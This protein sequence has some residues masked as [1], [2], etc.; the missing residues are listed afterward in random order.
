M[1]SVHG[2]RATRDGGTAQRF[3]LG[4]HQRYASLA[5]LQTDLDAFIDD[6]RT[7]RSHDGYRTKGRRP[8]ELFAAEACD[9]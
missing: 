9:R 6:Y 8:I 2:R 5:G 1:V 3:G 7:R 4:T